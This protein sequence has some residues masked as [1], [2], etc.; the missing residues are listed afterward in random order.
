MWNGAFTVAVSKPATLS[1][2]YRPAYQNASNA[3]DNVINCPSGIVT[4]HTQEEF[5]PWLKIDLQ[6]LYDIKQVTIFNRQD[7]YGRY[8]YNLFWI[9]S[10]KLI[11]TTTFEYVILSYCVIYQVIVYKKTV[12]DFDWFTVINYKKKLLIYQL[13]YKIIICEIHTQYYIKKGTNYNYT[14]L[15]TASII[16]LIRI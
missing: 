3:V 9:G 12:F 2:I 1:S 10:I 15:I 4:A 13:S 6:A 14:N 11:N 16:C 8:T 7:N 5:Q